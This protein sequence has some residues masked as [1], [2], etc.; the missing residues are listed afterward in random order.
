MF[1]NRSFNQGYP[2]NP[3]VDP[4]AMRGINPISIPKG[5]AAASRGGLLAGVGSKMSLNKMITSTQKSLNTINQI[6]PIYQ[7]I[8]PIIANTKD[9]A[10]VFKRALS[11]SPKSEKVDVEIV[12][13]KV[14]EAKKSTNTA[15]KKEYNPYPKDQ[16]EPN[17][18]FF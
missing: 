16:K 7:Q 3:P 9:F 2:F 4:N 11:K 8:K 5:S 17:R 14:Q 13:K 1:N 6:I 15:Q 18:P 10:K 12:E